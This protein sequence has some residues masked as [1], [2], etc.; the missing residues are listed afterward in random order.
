MGSVTF[1]YDAEAR[2]SGLPIVVWLLTKHYEHGRNVLKSNKLGD[3]AA[4]PN[5]E[6]KNMIEHYAVNLEILPESYYDQDAKYEAL[7]S[8]GVIFETMH[9]KFPKSKLS[10]TIETAYKQIVDIEMKLNDCL[11]HQN[12]DESDLKVKALDSEFNE[13]VHKT[14]KEI[15]EEIV[16][17]TDS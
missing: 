6:I 15:L 3:I 16:K 2:K 11:V 14:H 5:S 12:L 1:T 10:G 9:L 7:Q 13:L 8:L 4:W 17:I